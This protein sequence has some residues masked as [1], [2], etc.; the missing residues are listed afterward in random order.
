MAWG[1]SGI[2]ARR[3]EGAGRRRRRGTRARTARDVATRRS[4]GLPDFKLAL[5]EIYFLQIFE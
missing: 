1:G 4:V 5:L 3:R 2:E